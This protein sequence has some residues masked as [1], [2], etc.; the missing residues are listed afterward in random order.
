MTEPR[1]GTATFDPGQIQRRR[2]HGDQLAP[3]Y[4]NSPTSR[5]L[6][7]SSKTKSWSAKKVM[8]AVIIGGLSS[9]AQ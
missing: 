4:R 3:R 7:R 9:S 1:F 2:C 6:V 5:T 8:G